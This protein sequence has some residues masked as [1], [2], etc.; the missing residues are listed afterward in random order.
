MLFYVGVGNGDPSCKEPHHAAWRSA[1]NGLARVIVKVTED[2]SSSPTTR[3]LLRKIDAE[4]G[5]SGV[6]VADPA[7]PV[8]PQQ[9][10]IVVRASAP[11]LSSGTVAVEVSVDAANDGVLAAAHTSLRVPIS[12]D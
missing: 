9:P 11:G 8:T 3:K 4:S 1:Y 2:A 6:T 12:L 10:P 5:S 7:A